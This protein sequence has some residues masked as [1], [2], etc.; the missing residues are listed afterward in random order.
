M[1]GEV[2]CTSKQSK[3]K[4]RNVAS[5]K[6]TGLRPEYGEISCDQFPRRAELTVSIHDRFPYESS[7]RFLVAVI[8][9]DVGRLNM[10]A[11]LLFGFFFSVQ[12]FSYMQRAKR[13]S[14]HPERGPIRQMNPASQVAE[15]ICLSCILLGLE[16]LGEDPETQHK[17]HRLTFFLRRF[18]S[19]G[20]IEQD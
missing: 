12:Y 18:S 13:P 11:V 10:V 5:K 20:Y 14:L 17:V 9:N 7:R 1:A 4:A 15:R 2:C 3:W 6:Q 19:T 8:N 16:H